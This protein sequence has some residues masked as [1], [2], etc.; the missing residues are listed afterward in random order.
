MNRL[1][2]RIGWVMGVLMSCLSASHASWN[3]AGV[4]GGTAGTDFNAAANW[5]GGTVDGCFTNNTGATTLDLSGVASVG[6]LDCGFSNYLAGVSLTIG[7]GAGVTNTLALSGNITLPP[8]TNV[9]NSVTLGPD[10]ALSVS[11]SRTIS[12]RSAGSGTLPALTLNGPLVLAGGG[13]LA[14]SGGTLTINGLVSGSGSLTFG[15]GGSAGVL[16]LR[17]SANTF[18]GGILNGGW[19]SLVADSAV[20]IANKGMPSALGS[21]GTINVNNN[22]VILQGFSSIQRSDRDWNIGNNS[23]GINNNG[24]APLFLNGVFTNSVADGAL[25]LNGSYASGVNEIGGLIPLSVKATSLMIAGGS[26]RFTNAA[27][28]FTGQVSVTGGRLEFTSLSS[29][30]VP[31]ALGAGPGPIQMNNAGMA[32][33][34]RAAQVSD[35]TIKVNSSGGNG[36]YGVLWAN[37]QTPEATLTLSGVVSNWESGATARDLMLAGLNT[38]TNQLSGPLVNS[39]TSALNLTKKGAGTWVL[40]GTPKSLTGSLTLDGNGRLLLNYANGDVL[41]ATNALNMQGGI[42]EFIGTASASTEYVGAVTIGGGATATAQY[43]I[44]TFVVNKNGGGGMT[45]VFSTLANP[46]H[47]DVMFFDLVS[48]GVAKAPPSLVNAGLINAVGGNI[49]RTAGGY[50]I[51]TIDAASN[52]VALAATTDL[53]ASGGGDFHYRLNGSLALTGALGT[54][55][56]RINSTG[57]GQSLNLG[58]YNLTPTKPDLMF[59]G[60]QDYSI[61]G[62]GQIARSGGD[63]M[64]EQYGT[65]KLTVTAKIGS[66]SGRMIFFGAGGLIDWNS[67]ANSSGWMGVH[68]VTLRLNSSGPVNLTNA[69][70][71]NGSGQIYLSNDAVIE[72]AAGNLTRDLGTG[73]GQLS[74]IGNGGFSAF[75]ANRTVNF[76]SGATLAWD[77]TANFVKDTLI[78]GSDYSDSMVDL[79]NPVNL[80]TQYRVIEVRPGI[81]ANVDG[82][83]SGTLSGISAGIIKTGAGTLELTGQQT[84]IGDVI[85]QSGILRLGADRIFNGTNAVRLAGGTL[86]SGVGTNTFT[87]LEIKAGGTI[88]IDSDTTQIAFANCSNV[89]W[90][91]PLSITGV[92]SDTAL[93][94][95]TDGTGLSSDQLTNVTWNGVS[96]RLTSSGY[97]VRERRGTLITLQ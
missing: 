78:L 34:G 9:A 67:A 43:G 11:G 68:G 20:A 12:L 25:N 51:A 61:T 22:T 44:Q 70:S 2:Q 74:L 79:Q 91:G 76:N 37:G 53:P 90:T 3:G 19:S 63:A 38:G 10:V 88:N 26:W 69:G 73:A 8:A 6:Q 35:R 15:N 57:A 87:T 95:G 36:N 54:R 83:L 89:S 59:V 96:V 40:T 84:Y 66:S 85:I 93:R 81:N 48:G 1:F 56:L 50:D 21:N 29:N 41:A 47:F 72:L 18:S 64:I 31:S 92:T 42:I 52:I 75:G 14:L 77:S 58:A 82:R 97:L 60:S 80:G 7:D 28:S 45:T 30:G 24:G 86:Q 23:G 13:G 46:A 39:P 27:S 62:S 94:F 16:T 65:G 49:V 5:L 4:P 71:G 55:S 32:F 17:N 33:V